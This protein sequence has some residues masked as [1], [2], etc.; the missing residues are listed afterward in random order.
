MNRGEFWRYEPKGSPRQ[1]DVLIVSADGINAST[2][3][4]IYGLDVVDQDPGDILT[5]RL[6]DHRWADGTTLSRLWR[7][8]LTEPLG[9]V[10]GEALEAIDAMLRGALDL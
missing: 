6:D 7:D 4:W 10:S 5:V 8:W 2:R 1:R 9:S 3:R